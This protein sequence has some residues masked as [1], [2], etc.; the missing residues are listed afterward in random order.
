M[1]SSSLRLVPLPNDEDAL[2]PAKSLPSYI[3]VA[4]QT[5]ARWRSESDGPAWCCVG[6][7]VFYRTGTVRSWL[8]SRETQST[9]KK[10][11]GAEE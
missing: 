9:S 11:V 10:I 3:G 6:R 7:L 2:I 4:Y 8:R 5:L 1:A